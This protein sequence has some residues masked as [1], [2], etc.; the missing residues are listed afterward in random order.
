MAKPD[1]KRKSNESILIFFQLN[2]HIHSFN[3]IEE[4]PQ[5]Q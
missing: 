4:G 1:L 5:K 2:E 3:Q